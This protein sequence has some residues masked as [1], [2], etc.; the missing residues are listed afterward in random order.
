MEKTK[1]SDILSRDEIRR[2]SEPSDL[3]GWRAVASIWLVIGLAFAAV[4]LWPHPLVFVA[5]VLVVGGRQLALAILMHEASHY[6][7]FRTRAL[8]DFAGDWL[9]GRFIWIDVKRYR[10]HHRIHHTKTGT[11]QDTDLSLVTGFPTTRASLARKLARDITGLS[12]ARRVFGLAL[13]DLGLIKWTVANDVVRLPQAGRTPASYLGAAARNLGPVVAANAAL[14]G[15]LAA[16]GHLWVFS[17]W[18]VAYAT[19]FSLYLRIRSLAEHACTER[20]PDM[21]RNTRTTRAG[22]LARA[23]VAPLHVNY[24][25]EHHVLPSVPYFRL[26]EMHRMLRERGVVPAPPGY[27]DVLRLVSTPAATR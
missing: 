21:L 22:W 9:A 1:L 18:I 12:A 5:A 20:S 10:E 27:G 17:V 14:A 19:T 13:M 11:A 2:L 24:H 6:T 3:A 7:L 23:T 8:N 4:A 25:I 15:L 16:L 26:S